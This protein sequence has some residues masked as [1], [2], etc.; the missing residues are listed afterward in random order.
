MTGLTFLDGETMIDEGMIAMSFNYRPA[1][2]HVGGSLESSIVTIIDSNQTPPAGY[3]S[4]IEGQYMVNVSQGYVVPEGK[5]FLVSA[6]NNT[7]RTANE[8]Y[9]SAGTALPSGTFTRRYTGIL[10]NA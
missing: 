6:S 8:S 7:L 9:Y 4:V 10:I 2:Q 3:Y 5:I 1:A